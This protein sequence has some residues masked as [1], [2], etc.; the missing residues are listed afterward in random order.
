MDKSLKINIFGAS[1][2]GTTTL[3]RTLA[4]YFDYP[5]LDSDTYYWKLTDP[6][7]QIKHSPE[8]RQGNLKRDF[9]SHSGVVLTGGM[10]SWGEGWE[11]CFDVAFFLYLSP[12]VRMQRLRKRE[13]ER[14]GET[15]EHDP[16]VQQTSVEF[17][18]WAAGYDDPDFDGKSITRHRKWME[19]IT[20]PVISIENNRT[21]EWLLKEALLQMEA[22]EL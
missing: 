1:G 7:F 6:P 13:R 15:L 22:L 3:G 5:F 17:L 20:Y 19:R 8:T 11:S 10:M 9:L 12:D 2:A 16:I 4:K 14:Y 18:E 21:E